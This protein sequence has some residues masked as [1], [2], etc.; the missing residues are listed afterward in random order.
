MERKNDG[1]H[2]SDSYYNPGPNSGMKSSISPAAR[3]GH[4]S[5]SDLNRFVPKPARDCMIKTT[6][7]SAGPRTPGEVSSGDDK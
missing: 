2:Y 3:V 6:T 5:R 1:Q 4:E 7:G